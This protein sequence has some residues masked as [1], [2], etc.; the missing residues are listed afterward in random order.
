MRWSEPR[1]RGK[2]VYDKYINYLG[3]FCQLLTFANSLDL[4][5]AQQKVSCD[6]YPNCLTLWVHGLKSLSLC[7]C[8]QVTTF[9]RK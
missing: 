7:R 9:F 2:H 6:Q 5:Q 8:V 1:A 4:D 3:D